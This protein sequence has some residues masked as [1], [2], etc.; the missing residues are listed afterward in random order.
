M[1]LTQHHPDELSIAAQLRLWL[2]LPAELPQ[3]ARRAPAKLQLGEVRLLLQRLVVVKP[4]ERRLLV[5][6]L[7]A[8]QSAVL[9]Q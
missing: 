9:Q 7:L 1:P 8:G 5:Q 6:S 2:C 3:A 4:A